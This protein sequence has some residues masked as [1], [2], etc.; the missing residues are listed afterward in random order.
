MWLC[1][2]DCG[3]RK[4]VQSNNLLRPGGTKSCGCLRS[5]ANARK[6]K[7]GGVW[8]AGKTY[9]VLGGLKRYRSKQAWAKAVIRHYGNECRK[10]GWNKAR[11]DAHHRTP[12]SAG[13]AN[14]IENGIVLCPNCHRVEH[15][16]KAVDR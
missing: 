11:C 1:A 3:G 14:T 12:R 4:V 16:G 10:C 5:E 2:C 13:G 6:R 8:N 9:P 15:E 7:S